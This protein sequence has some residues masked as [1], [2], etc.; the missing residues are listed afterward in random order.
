MPSFADKHG[1]HTRSARTRAAARGRCGI[2]A[3]P[4][5]GVRGG[6]GA[7]AGGCR[8]CR[9]TGRPPAVAA[10]SQAND[11]QGLRVAQVEFRGI[12]ANPPVMENLRRLVAPN[13]DQPLDRQRL[14]RT[15]RALYATG[16]FADVQVDAQRNQ[17]NEL[18]LV[19]IATENLFIGSITVAGAPRRPS[20]A[21]LR[22][23]TKLELGKPYSPAAVEQGMER[24]KSL[25]VGNGYYQS[26]VTV[27]EERHPESQQI[28][29]HFSVTP[30]PAAKIGQIIVTGSPGL[31]DAEILRISKLQPGATVSSGACYA[32]AHPAAQAV[33]Q[34]RAPGS[35]DRGGG[36][37]LS[38][39]EQHA[40]LRVPHRAR[41]GGQYQRRRSR[42][43]RDHQAQAAAVRSG[44]RGTRRGRRPAE[45]GPAEICAII[46][47][48]WA[49]ST[50]R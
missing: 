25:L 2:G 49:T 23:A 5:D 13:L 36:A 31:S 37:P 26:A 3:A 42:S 18:S 19:F 32:R 17:R 40:G 21:Q 9:A 6:A 14:G 22:D 28:K 38:C 48:P 15:V 12:E 44:V 1:I 33:F 11:L 20:A 4:G 24:I 16:R 10:L 43:R 47:R 8:P 50:P 41:P 27:N 39:G 34:E 35:P 7:R 46:F 29:L 30:G 45:R